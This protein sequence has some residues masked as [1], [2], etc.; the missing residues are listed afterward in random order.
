MR[1]FLDEYPLVYFKISKTLPDRIEELDDIPMALTSYEEQT[2]FAD[3][4]HRVLMLDGYRNFKKRLNYLGSY[5]FK[6]EKHI[7]RRYYSMYNKHVPTIRDDGTWFGLIKD[8]SI[9]LR[10]LIF[11]MDVEKEFGKKS[12]KE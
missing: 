12:D 11:T 10:D 5:E 7:G 9:L 2:E 4:D 1:G 6:R 3:S 8:W